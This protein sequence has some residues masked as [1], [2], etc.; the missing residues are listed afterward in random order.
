MFDNT[1]KHFYC[2]F[3]PLKSS[4]QYHTVNAILN[5]IAIVIDR[6]PN[7]VAQ[8]SNLFCLGSVAQAQKFIDRLSVPVVSRM[9]VLEVSGAAV[10]KD[11]ITRGL[12]YFKA[13]HS[14]YGS[15]ETS[16]NYIKKYTSIED[17]DSHM[18]RPIIDSVGAEIVD[19]LDNILPLNQIG[20]IRLPYNN[21]HASTYLNVDSSK[22]FKHGYFYPGDL[23]YKDAD[24]NLYITGRA[25]SNFINIG[26]HKIDPV[27][28]ESIIRTSIQIDCML[29]KHND[30][31]SIMLS[32][33]NLEEILDAVINLIADK[34]GV[35][36]LPK[37]YYA[38]DSIPLNANG[39][40]DR[41]RANDFVAKI[42]PLIIQVD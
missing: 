11:F 42:N 22:N 28:I 30:Q 40:L 6:D 26:G 15:T 4:S 18:G 31:L 13:V 32:H 17:F 7:T 19:N 25:E 36:S 24:H 39:K 21:R 41:Q 8:Y 35:A 1:I 37:L 5:G 14:S 12:Q 20:H 9:D 2:F 38:V 10:S 27:A 23:G 3:M 34:F 29:F 16:R 33:S